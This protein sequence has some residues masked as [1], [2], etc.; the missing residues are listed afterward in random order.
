[1]TELPQ[2]WIEKELGKFVTHKKGTKPDNLYREP[3]ESYVPYIDIKAFE[4]HIIEQ[5]TEKLTAKLTRQGNILVV[6]DGAR[7]G[8][9]GISPCE[10]AIGSTLV[11]IEP[12]SESI[13]T[14]YLY[15][16]LS[17]KYQYI[18]SKP[19]G[20]GTPHVN[21]DLYW[22]MEI[23]L[24]P[25][26]EQKR[27]VKKLDAI[28]PKVDEVNSRLER[29][30]LIL[31]RARQSILNQAITGELTKD[32]RKEHNITESWETT[33]FKS[34]A[35][36]LTDGSHNPPPKKVEGYPVISA[37]NIKN[38]QIVIDTVERYTDEEGF[39]KENK[40][41]NIKYGDIIL[42]IIGASIG[43]IA[44][45]KLN[46][47]VIAQRSIAIIDTNINN[48]YVYYYMSSPIYQN[49]L[50]DKTKGAAQGGVYLSE[51][52]SIEIQVPTME[53]QEEIV[54]QVKKAFE[55]LD[56][57][58]EQYKKAKSYTDRITQSILHKAFTGNLVPQDPND[59]PVEINEKQMEIKNKNKTITYEKLIHEVIKM[60]K[61]LIEIIED[62]PNG[63]FPEDLF[64]KSKYS[65]TNY[66]DEDII[67]FYKELSELMDSKL[68]EEKDSKHYYT[69]IKKG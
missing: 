52:G 35:T 22:N 6:W 12:A 25:K 27:I 66:T 16:Y 23:P 31:K 46:Q 68:I 65:K 9:V 17:S 47:K 41:T 63:I 48:E 1:M 18:N 33:T 56:K 38:N 20:S 2:N 8:L 40:R 21:P 10:G 55:K 15:H 62:Y 50:I 69:V 49:C 43:N 3:H 26:N 67:A 19:R 60:K 54:K 24:P 37:K 11:D 7:A 57:I 64:N 53:E 39:L 44:I 13:D 29:V 61:N 14:K 45:Y 5:Y 51:L 30:P 58:E 32:W 4:K 59:K 28:I 36:K 42:G 34:I